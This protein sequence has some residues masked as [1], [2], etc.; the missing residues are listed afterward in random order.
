M[1][2]GG[3]GMAWRPPL[4]HSSSATAAVLPSTRPSSGSRW[5]TLRPRSTRCAF[6]ATPGLPSMAARVPRSRAA[7]AAS[8]AARIKR[9]YGITGDEYARMLAEQGG[10]CFLC[11]KRSRKRLSVDH[12]HKTKRV[13]GLLCSRCNRHLGTFEWHVDVLRRLISYA[14]AIIADRQR[15]GVE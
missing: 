9:L 6:G 13:R 4:L 14:E 12:D 15:A 10:R 2:R 5:T 1:T 3:G 11:G 7:S 8:H